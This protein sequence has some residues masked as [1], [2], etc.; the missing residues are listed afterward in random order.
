M[1][2]LTMF[3]FNIKAKIIGAVTAFF[4]VIALVFSIRRGAVNDT[5]NKV[6]ADRLK[7]AV[8]ADRRIDHAD[9]SGGDADDDLEWLRRR[10][11]RRSK[12]TGRKTRKTD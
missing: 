8:E 5:L 3:G 1:G 2:D 6:E 9:V 4:A 12:Q 7:G 10:N 11:A